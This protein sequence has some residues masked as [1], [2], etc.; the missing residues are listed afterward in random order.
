MSRPQRILLGLSA[1]L[2]VAAALNAPAAAEETPVPPQAG[3][4]M[5]DSPWFN[6]SWPKVSMPEIN[7]KP[8][9]SA[10]AKP[11]SKPRENP[12]AQTLER[13][14]DMS[15]RAAESVR[16]GWGSMVSKLPFGQGSNRAGKTA[17][18]DEPGFFARMFQPEPSRGSE[19]VTEF[20]AQ[21]RPSQ[22]R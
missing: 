19:T 15:G 6:M 21:D 4:P 16:A 20:L 11:D 1:L 2:I 5:V 3:E 13:V 9:A 7:W 10:D 12:V 22:V 14:S 18:K 8:W 17:S